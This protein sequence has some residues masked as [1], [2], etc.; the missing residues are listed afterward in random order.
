MIGERLQL[1][2]FFPFL[3]S[4]FGVCV[5]GVGGVLKPPLRKLEHILIIFPFPFQQFVGNPP[6]D[7]ALRRI[8]LELVYPANTTEPNKNIWSII[9]TPIVTNQVVYNKIGSKQWH[10]SSSK[11]GKVA[12]AKLMHREYLLKYTCT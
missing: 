5:C 7:I 3:A 8:Y 10:N 2:V 12:H 9:K 6:N 11:L 1:V 4:F